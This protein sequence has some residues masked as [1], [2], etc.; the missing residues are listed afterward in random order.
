MFVFCYTRYI[1][2]GIFQGFASTEGPALL[3]DILG[4]TDALYYSVY[5]PS[6]VDRRGQH[7]SE[8]KTKR[9][10]IYLVVLYQDYGS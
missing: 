9:K 7:L 4:I 6:D 1:E 8:R 10:G 2:G 3:K 5:T